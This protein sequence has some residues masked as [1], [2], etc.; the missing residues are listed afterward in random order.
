[1]NS[2]NSKTIEPHRVKLDL[3]DKLNLKHPNK[4][5]S[6]ANLIIFYTWQNLISE[7]KNNK[8]K[9]SALT[10]NDEFELPDGSYSISDIE[11]YFGLIIMK[12]KTLTENP[13]LQIYPNKIK[14]GIVFKIETGYKLDLLTPETMILLGSTKKDVDEDKDGKNVPQLES[15]E[16]IL[17]HCNLFKNNYQHTSKILF[18]FVPNKLFGKL[19]NI[20][21]HSL[22]MMNTVNT[23]FSSVEVWFT[24]EVSKALETED[25][26]SLILIIGKDIIKMRYPTESRYR[27]YIKG[28]GFLSFAKKFGDKYG[29][30]LMNTA[31]KTGIDAAKTASKRV[32]QKTAEATGWRF[33]W[34]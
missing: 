11:D 34:K 9:I 29:K 1:M 17:V 12:Q 19:I 33:D 2:E 13:P 7:Y 30:E 23:E 21:P 32:V 15:V 16:V 10:W 6:L 8:F 4:N 5:M 18:A 25:N 3:A 14:N 20:S 22:T 24:N 26:V 27:K 28:Y 31:T